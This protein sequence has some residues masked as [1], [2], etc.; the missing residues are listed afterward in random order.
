M[1]DPALNAAATDGNAVATIVESRV[2][3]RIHR[4]KLKNT[5]ITLLN[6][7]RFVWSVKTTLE[8]LD[9]PGVSVPTGVHVP[10]VTGVTAGLGLSEE[11]ILSISRRG[12]GCCIERVE[13]GYNKYTTI[14][15]DIPVGRRLEVYSIACLN[16]A[17][18]SW[19]RRALE[20]NRV[21]LLLQTYK[22]S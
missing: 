20:D 3:T 2:D 8:G 21:M 18:L 1:I 10:S 5:T 15:P 19:L 17:A 6:G 9:L 16:I 14:G 22:R 4:D 12:K 13:Q 7:R 11:L